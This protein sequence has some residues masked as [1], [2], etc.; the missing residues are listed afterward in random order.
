[1]FENRE[2]AARQIADRLQGRQFKMPL[3][4][5][6]PRGGAVLGAA[7]ANALGADFDIILARKLRAPWNPQSVIGAV[8]EDRQYVLNDDAENMP[9]LSD[10]FFR[11]ES[12]I[13]PTKSKNSKGYID[14]V[15]PQHGFVNDRSS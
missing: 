15:V 5:A 3:V 6:I 13:N 11:E 12:K 14:T 9:G 8:C 4:L 2:E 7:L 1:M 10:D